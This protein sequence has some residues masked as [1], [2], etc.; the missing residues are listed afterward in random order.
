MLVRGAPDVSPP[1]GL[2][3]PVVV[4]LPRHG[5]VKLTAV[6]LHADDVVRL[7]G[8]VRAVCPQRR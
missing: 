4:D 7:V 1:V 8:A 6:H 5:T 3:E 2:G